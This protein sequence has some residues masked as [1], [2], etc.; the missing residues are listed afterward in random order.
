MSEKPTLYGFPEIVTVDSYVATGSIF[1]DTHGF[2]TR[3]SVIFA[4]GQ[5]TLGAGTRVGLNSGGTAAGVHTSSGTYD[6]GIGVL[7]HDLNTS[8]NASLSCVGTVQRIGNFHASKCN[9]AAFAVETDTKQDC[10]FL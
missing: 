9:G 1:Y 10:R 3:F 6:D 8:A 7:I 4:Q 5:G 2:E